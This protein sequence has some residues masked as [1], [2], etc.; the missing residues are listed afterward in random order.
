MSEQF[1]SLL[2]TVLHL[3]QR[4]FE[5]IPESVVRDLLRLHADAGSNSAAVARK[6]QEIVERHLREGESRAEVQ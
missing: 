1:S 2:E 5:D 3:R 4:E 6:A